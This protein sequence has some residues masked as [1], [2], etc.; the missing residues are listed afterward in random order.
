VSGHCTGTPIS[1]A[2][3]RECTTDGC[4]PAY[5]CT[6]TWLEVTGVGWTGKT[7]LVWSPRASG[8]K[9][10]VAT[11]RVAELSI[12]GGGASESCLVTD[13]HATSTEATEAPATRTTFWYLVRATK[14][15]CGVGTYGF[16]Y[17]AGLPPVE[18][19]LTVCP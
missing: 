9:Y 16:R 17:P 11:G 13:L 3:D 1:C 6:Y 10:D 15:P 4:L 8:A 14:N 7:T 5:G 12:L 18:R 2:D 19:I